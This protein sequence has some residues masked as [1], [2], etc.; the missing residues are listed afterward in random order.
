MVSERLL[1][2]LSPSGQPG[3]HKPLRARTSSPWF[4]T[5]I[6]QYFDE[7]T[8]YWDQIYTGGKF[9]NWHLARRR[10]LVLE[11]V[12]RIS[13]GRAL[14]ILDLGSGSG[15]LTRDLLQMGHSVVAVDL[16]ENMIR[17]LTRSIRAN[18]S[19]RFVG[20]TIGSA[21]AVCFRKEAFDVVLCVGVIQYQLHPE[22][23][24][25][26]ISRLL[27]SGGSCVF[28]V[29]NQLSLHHLLDPWCSVR[30]IYRVAARQFAKTG[31]WLLDSSELAIKRSTCTT[32]IF[33]RRYFR[34]EI[35]SL[36]EKQPLRIRNTIGFGY[37][38]L[39]LSNKSVLPDRLSIALS[40]ALTRVSQLRAFSSLSVL[41]NRW[42][43]V[44]EKP[45]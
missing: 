27:R 18:A 13:N 15:V 29:P 45:A 16:S 33:E 20:A 21:S 36:L 7:T 23:V 22:T 44:V 30:Y 26:E 5:K 6:C 9:I 17:T 12:R 35:P 43:I 32:D 39:T 2:E 34:R 31:S 8:S 40:K 41:V 19:G 38:P 1:S 24:F 14:H 10:E 28:T 25:D 4:D 37:G 3:D 42:V 11:A